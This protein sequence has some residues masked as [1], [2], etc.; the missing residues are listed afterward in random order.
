[1][2]SNSKDPVGS[3]AGT[4]EKTIREDK[5]NSPRLVF[6]QAKGKRKVGLPTMESDEGAA[7]ATDRIQYAQLGGRKGLSVYVPLQ[8]S[9]G[10]LVNAAEQLD[11]GA[12]AELV[13]VLSRRLAERGRERV[14]ATAEQARR[15]FAAGQCQAMTAHEIIREGLS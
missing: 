7:G 9:F 4:I 6:I 13:A 8:I 11:I 15:E 14:A 10:D 5:Y 12:Q 1:M 3:I 2:T